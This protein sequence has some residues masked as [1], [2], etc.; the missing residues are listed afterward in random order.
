MIS[1][2]PQAFLMSVSFLYHVHKISQEPP[3]QCTYTP[4]SKFYIQSSP[5]LVTNGS[6]IKQ[7]LELSDFFFPSI[8]F[9]A[10]F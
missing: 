6:A 4:E 10:M 1:I 9:A 8:T 5:T 7:S 2:R 3:Q